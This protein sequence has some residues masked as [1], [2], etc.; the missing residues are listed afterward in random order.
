M[1]SEILELLRNTSEYVSGQELCH[2]F[3]VSRTAVWKAI[4]SLKKDGYNI[5]AVRNRGY[6]LVD[7]GEDVFCQ[8]ELDACLAESG[9]VTK[10]LFFEE[11]GSTNTEAKKMAEEGEGEGLLLVADRQTSG[12]GRRGREWVSPSG[13]NAYYTLMLK[14]QFAPDKAPMLTLV[15]AMAVAKAI[16]DLQPASA[17]G[18]DKQ[19]TIKWPNDILIGDKK[20]C[21]ILTEMSAEN[22]YIHYV[23]IGVGINIKPQDF[24]EEIKDK[25]TC[26]DAEWNIKTKRCELI[27]NIMKHFE[28]Y[29][30]EFIKKEDLSGLKKEYEKL[31]VN[32]GREVLVL[33]PKGEYKG[34]ALGITDTGEL[35]VKKKNGAT[36]EV[37][38]GEVSVRG[39]YGYGR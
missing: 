4:E 8:R 6:K 26:I 30:R 11:I 12:R 3:G 34:K 32:A 7:A 37:Y 39:I 27:G 15:M 23:V 33:D 25:A 2:K 22:D 10:A 28:K 29:Y 16:K 24:D 9:L 38:A 35:I 20:I 17:K 21:G 19:V 5:E 18:E 1:R 36:V 14:P 31:L 13:K